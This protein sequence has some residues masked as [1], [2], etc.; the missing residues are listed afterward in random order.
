MSPVCRS[1]SLESGTSGLRSLCLL[2]EDKW[3]RLPD[4]FLGN[5]RQSTYGKEVF[6]ESYPCQVSPTGG[7]RPRLGRS[8]PLHRCRPTR[9]L[10]PERSS[11]SGHSHFS[12]PYRGPQFPVRADLSRHR[13]PSYPRMDRDPTQPM[14]GLAPLVPFPRPSDQPQDDG[15]LSQYPLAG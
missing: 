2:Q 5:D 4:P 14:R 11:R 3:S 1:Q 10:R 7:L 13:L 15:S 6:P 9:D 12:R 8:P